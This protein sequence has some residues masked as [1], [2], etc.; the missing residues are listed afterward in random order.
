MCVNTQFSPD[1]AYCVFD[2]DAS[3]RTTVLNDLLTA[4]FFNNSIKISV[5]AFEDYRKVIATSV[6]LSTFDSIITSG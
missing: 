5:S 2:A 1:S 4:K 6:R 3:E